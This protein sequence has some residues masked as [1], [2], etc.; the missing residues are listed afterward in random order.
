MI[1]PFTASPEELQELT[2][3]EI[4]DLAYEI[5]NDQNLGSGERLEILIRTLEDARGQ[6]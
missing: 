2:D 4:L 6:N 3:G 1:N 5:V